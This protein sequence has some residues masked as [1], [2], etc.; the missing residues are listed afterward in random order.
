MLQEK[1]ISVL[2]LV[3]LV[4]MSMVVVSEVVAQAP[5]AAP[6]QGS[7]RNRS[8]RQGQQV[9]FHFLFPSG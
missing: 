5:Q 9:P 4:V 7:G 6:N 3:L 2:T 8:C 1:K